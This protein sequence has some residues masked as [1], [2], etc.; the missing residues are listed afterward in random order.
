MGL[1]E[2][3][4]NL[5]TSP[6]NDSSAMKE[7]DAVIE[8]AAP[9]QDASLLE[10]FEPENFDS[11]EMIRLDS[12]DSIFNEKSNS[13]PIKSD[14]IIIDD[15][16]A[17]ESDDSA[18]ND[19]L[20]D[21]SS[22]KEEVVSFDG[23][24]EDFLS[25]ETE[26]SAEEPPMFIPSAVDDTVASL[27]EE[28]LPDDASLKSNDEIQQSFDEQNKFDSNDPFSDP[29][30][31]LD[32]KDLLTDIDSVEKN[33]P[34]PE[35]IIF[36]TAPSV[37]DDFFGVLN[38]A[39]RELLRSNSS[40]DFFNVL[41]LLVM[42]QFTASS[43]A[44][45]VPINIEE[46][47]G[48]WTLRDVR[49]IRLKNRSVTFRGIDPLMGQILESRN[50]LDIE[51]FASLD[52]FREECSI[53]YSI[54]GRYILPIR[55]KGVTRV[56]LALGDKISG[57]YEP[58]EI[59]NMRVYASTVS[60][61]FERLMD[62]EKITEENCQYIERNTEYSDIDKIERDL[63]R[64]SG[65]ADIESMIEEKMNHYGAESFCFFVHNE[66][67][68]A[69]V[70]RFC[71][72]A[73]LMG[74]KS[75]GFSIPA[76][77]ELCSYFIQKDE[78]EDFENPASF[79]PLRSVFTDT[80]IIKMNLCAAYPF[81]MRGYIAGLLILMRGKRERIADTK[82]H[83]MRLSRHVFSFLQGNAAI[84]V[85]EN[86]FSD[87]IGKPMLRMEKTI[88]MAD[89][90]GITVSFILFHLKNLKRYRSIYGTA[91]S[92]NLMLKI[93]EIIESRISHS[94]YGIRIESGKVIVILPG[95]TKKY[96]VP[97]S[98]A[99]RNE[100][101]ASFR[102]RESQIMLTYLIAEYPADGKTLYDIL[103]YLS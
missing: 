102:E 17:G 27:N 16:S 23:E 2:R 63:R 3:A 54:G 83:I 59:E 77:S 90:L 15:I 94:D 43:A 67:G 81:L 79:N 51:E 101:N 38:E 82:M 69:L 97:F 55:A 66:R 34:R 64:S 40:E 26:P 14:D 73:D 41:L 13:V 50:I 20:I 70:P 93:R 44:I 49:G 48:K 31:A 103:D 78:W 80:H 32:E 42:G 19:F 10:N 52:G 96:A 98:T 33:N 68:D 1:L 12:D 6:V 36:P 9:A 7:A 47:Q 57:D 39:S 88:S 35:P 86:P 24:L 45:L 61:I 30:V 28:V 18:D 22:K 100:V 85:Y 5:K 89:D 65:G 46:P 62:I 71:E 56:I 11:A 8:N 84:S 95:K 99:V 87:I 92:E 21:D 4:K 58:S 60:P 91:D 37:S 72:K 29:E 74:L 75:S 76:E 53:F 25:T